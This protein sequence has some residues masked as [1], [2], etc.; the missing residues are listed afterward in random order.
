MIRRDFVSSE[1]VDPIGTVHRI[2]ASMPRAHRFNLKLKNQPQFQALHDHLIRQHL[3]NSV[4]PDPNNPGALVL[5]GKSTRILN[6]AAISPLFL[7]ATDVHKAKVLA[8][9][10]TVA[11]GS[12]E[13]I[14]ESDDDED[15]SDEDEEDEEEEGLSDFMSDDDQPARTLKPRKKRKKMVESVHA[16]EYREYFMAG[17]DKEF[18]VKLATDIWD[19]AQ[20]LLVVPQHQQLFGKKHPR[21]LHPKAIAAIIIQSS[22]RLQSLFGGVA[23]QIDVRDEKSVIFAN[24][25]WEQMLYVVLLRV[26]NIAA[27]AVLAT[28]S[29]DEKQKNVEHFQQPLARWGNPAFAGLAPD[30]IEVLVLSYHMNSGLNLH[31]NCH[32]LHAPSP[33]PSYAIWVQSCGRIVRFGQEF[34]CVIIQYHVEGTY[35]TTQMAVVM[36]NALASISALMCKNDAFGTDTDAPLTRISSDALKHLH[37]YRG[38]VIDDRQPGFAAALTSGEVDLRLDDK[39]KFLRVLN[40]VLGLSVEVSG[41]VTDSDY[42][43][44]PTEDL[45]STFGLVENQTRT[46]KSHRLTEKIPTPKST[47]R[48]GSLSSAAAGDGGDFTVPTR[49]GPLQVP[50]WSPPETPKSGKSGKSKGGR[51][52]KSGAGKRKRGDDTAESAADSGMDSTPSAPRS[53]RQ[54][55]A[56]ASQAIAATS[57]LGGGDVGAG[58]GEDMPTR[59]TRPARAP[60]RPPRGNKKNK[61]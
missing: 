27:A 11:H 24:N 52:G 46:P 23:D 19:N 1:V 53:K 28:M 6:L 32:N 50:K 36:K 40:T 20:T 2:G 49:S 38:S 29:G 7:L 48:K 54:A 3:S 39:T 60:V 30:D 44:E 17:K 13:T 41:N 37:G 16:K 35:N 26:F 57:S 33:P 4:A 51:G 5:N 43:F 45:F 31:F 56:K 42:K 55:A 15:S 18:L 12:H 8:T 34:E 10:T 47:P 25:P 21:E 9:K 58:S 22:V 59:T 61:K 14:V